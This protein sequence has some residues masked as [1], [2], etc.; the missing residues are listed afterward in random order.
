MQKQPK[1]YIKY[2]FLIYDKND[3]INFGDKNKMNFTTVEKHLT[4]LSYNDK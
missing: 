2:F 1:K 4:I 3:K